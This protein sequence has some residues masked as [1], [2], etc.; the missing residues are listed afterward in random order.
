MNKRLAKP[1]RNSLEKRLNGRNGTPREEHSKNPNRIKLGGH[2]KIKPIGLS[3]R[4]HVGLSK[5]DHDNKLL[6]GPNN[7]SPNVTRPTAQKRVAKNQLSEIGIR[8]PS[9]AER[10]DFAIDPNRKSSVASKRSLSAQ[11]S[12][13]GR[14]KCN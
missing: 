9:K 7:S 8:L 6:S 2:S 3:R 5:S 12:R 13:P 1:N 10:A 14:V 4:R 11:A